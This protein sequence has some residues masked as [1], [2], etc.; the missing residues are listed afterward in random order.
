MRSVQDVMT[1]NTKGAHLQ[2]ASSVSKTCTHRCRAAFHRRPF[3]PPIHLPIPAQKIAVW[4]E[5][6]MSLSSPLF[7]DPFLFFSFLLFNRTSTDA[8]H[9]S[10]VFFF[11]SSFP[12]FRSHHHHHHS[13]PFQDNWYYYSIE[14]VCVTLFIP[15]HASSMSSVVCNSMS[16]R[17]ESVFGAPR[18]SSGPIDTWGSV[19]ERY[20]VCASTRGP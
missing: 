3:F 1:G 4:I 18:R 12:S 8:V 11:F 19:L 14:C 9:D 5:R 17:T 13:I 2:Y 10:R 15:P 20:C 16:S 7:S 6:G